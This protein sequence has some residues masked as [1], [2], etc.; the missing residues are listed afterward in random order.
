MSVALA[1]TGFTHFQ[2]HGFPK[3]HKTPFSLPNAIK[4]LIKTRQNAL[5]STYML[6]FPE[7]ICLTNWFCYDVSQF[8]SLWDGLDTVS[9]P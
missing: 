1:P 6:Q 7:F 4:L 9:L 2:P 8:W 5:G 3:T